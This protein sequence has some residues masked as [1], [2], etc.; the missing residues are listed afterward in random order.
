LFI[1]VHK[2]KHSK[3]L[4]LDPDYFLLN[5]IFVKE[6]IAKINGE[7]FNKFKLDRFLLYA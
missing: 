3:P 1:E 7:N 6:F 5:P 4:K 2:K